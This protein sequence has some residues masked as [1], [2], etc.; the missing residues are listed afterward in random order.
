MSSAIPVPAGTWVIDPEHSVV[1]FSNRA[2]RFTR[3]R[4]RF[5]EFSGRLEIAADPAASVAT[6]S[7]AVASIDTGVALRDKHLRSALFFDAEKYPEIGFAS[8]AI[9]LRGAGEFAVAGELTMHGHTRPVTFLVRVLDG[10][11]STGRVH[12][13]ASAEVDRKD[14]GMV[15]DA[16]RELIVGDLAE[17]KLDLAAV[18]QG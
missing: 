15:A 18:R 8:T 1:G 12:L 6:G 17:L 9:E 4:G 13:E 3:V 2:L 10:D 16:V 11:A 5:G 14:Y 7:V